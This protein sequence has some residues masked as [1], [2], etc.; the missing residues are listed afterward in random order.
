[1]RYVL[2]GGV[3][4]LSRRKINSVVHFAGEKLALNI[5]KRYNVDCAFIH[6]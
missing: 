1:L 6:R 2:G 3:T 4:S 5:G